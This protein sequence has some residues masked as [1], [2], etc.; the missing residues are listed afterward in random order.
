MG[1]TRTSATKQKPRAGN[2][3][4]SKPGRGRRGS[5]KNTTTAAR[6]KSTTNDNK[7]SQASNKKT[8]APATSP[9]Q[10]STPT[11]VSPP[12]DNNVDVNQPMPPLVNQ[13]AEVTNT[14][15]GLGGVMMTPVI[16]H[17]PN[18]VQDDYRK[19]S[20]DNKQSGT[21]DDAKES[22]GK[23]IGEL[24]KVTK[25]LP[26]S[27][28]MDRFPVLRTWAKKHVSECLRAKVDEMWNEV[29]SLMNTKVGDRRSTS[30]KAMT[31]K[32]W[33]ELVVLLSHCMIHP[34]DLTTQPLFP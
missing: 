7:K 22:I 32:F 25:Y 5:G 20:Q 1:A 34:A 9:S 13:P 6:N 28:D 26:N 21:W 19:Q 33:G 11:V 16:H 12:T 3:P 2:R 23:K 24:Y 29:K 15:E 30:T 10:N 4:P 31:K 18:L 17:H 14:G 27:Y 8:V